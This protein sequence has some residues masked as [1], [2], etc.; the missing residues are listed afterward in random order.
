MQ[1]D[2]YLLQPTYITVI[3]AITQY[4]ALQ[5]TVYNNS[6]NCCNVS[7]LKKVEI[8]LCYLLLSVTMVTVGTTQV[9]Q[10]PLTWPGPQFFMV[11][12]SKQFS[13]VVML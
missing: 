2:F 10:F 3:L 13:S 7:W 9:L 5:C 8:K 11:N 12:F 1:F 4:I 6:Q